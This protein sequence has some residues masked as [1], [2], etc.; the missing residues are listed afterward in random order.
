MESQLQS[1]TKPIGTGSLP[2]LSLLPG[3]VQRDSRYVA[4]LSVPIAQSTKLLRIG[5]NVARVIGQE[6]MK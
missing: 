1:T 5:K 2:S 3:I 6:L 4:R